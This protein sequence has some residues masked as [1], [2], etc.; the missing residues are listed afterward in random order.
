LHPQ[1]AAE[2]FHVHSWIA[3]ISK[4]DVYR[5]NL[6]CVVQRSVPRGVAQQQIRAAFNVP[7]EA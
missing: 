5:F 2:L 4:N 6:Y 7:G 3:S 1:Q